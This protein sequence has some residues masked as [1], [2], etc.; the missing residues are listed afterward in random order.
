M[1]K[2]VEVYVCV[3]VFYVHI[4]VPEKDIGYFSL[5]FSG[6]FPWDRLSHWTWSLAVSWWGWLLAILGNA[7]S[8]YPTAST[9]LIDTCVTT[10]I[11]F[12]WV[13]KTQ[14]QALN[15]WVA[16]CFT[17]RAFSLPST[18]CFLHEASIVQDYCSLVAVWQYPQAFVVTGETRYWGK[19][20]TWAGKPCSPAR[21]SLLM[22]RACQC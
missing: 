22:Q 8:L 13:L 18:E 21:V 1:W 9:E 11:I 4:S 15:T 16:S 7:L 20:L 12:T 2:G 19:E 6:L 10:P 17:H 14:T 3:C 5:S